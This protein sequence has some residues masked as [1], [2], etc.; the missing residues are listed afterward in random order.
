M[1]SPYHG[2]E[3]AL[4]SGASAF[5][6]L[7]NSGL[8][9]KCVEQVNRD[10]SL[11]LL[12]KLPEERLPTH[13][14]NLTDV[15]TRIGVLLEYS[16]ALALQDALRKGGTADYRASFVVANQYPDLVI[17]DAVSQP[18]VRIEMKT[19][20]LVS[21]EKSANFD[22]LIRDV[23]PQ[24]DILCVLMWEWDEEDLSGTTVK[25]PEVKRGFAFEAYP[26]ARVRDLGWLS[27]R[28]AG[29][30]KGIDVT[31]PVV[32]D[33]Q[34]LREEEHNMGK[35]MRILGDGEADALPDDLAMHRAVE[36]YREFKNYTISAGLAHNAVRLLKELGIVSQADTAFSHSTSLVQS[37]ALGTREDG[38]KGVVVAAAGRIT[39][40]RLKAYGESLREAGTDPALVLV[41]NEKFNWS[42]YDFDGSSLKRLDSGKKFEGALSEVSLRLIGRSLA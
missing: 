39:D 14:R 41:F 24:K 11:P 7:L 3:A 8:M 34:S 35:L 22:A 26:I 13:Q 21:E 9:D 25:F 12:S 37:V 42:V 36:S 33:A 10:F 5:V 17:R 15:R 20:E 6:D 4:R 27:Q 28:R 29:Q 16:F 30:V 2:M 40:G 31:G 19:L 38:E 23:H 18:A 1:T 32:G